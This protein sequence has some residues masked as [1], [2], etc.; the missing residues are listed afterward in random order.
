MQRPTR[1]EY[2]KWAK[3]LR[4]LQAVM[5]IYLSEGAGTLPAQYQCGMAFNVP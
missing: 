2:C 5:F 4:Q 3:L 1:H